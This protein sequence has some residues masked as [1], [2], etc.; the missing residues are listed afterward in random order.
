VSGDESLATA[1]V[2]SARRVHVPALDGMR[3]IGILA[4]MVIHFARVDPGGFGVHA[5]WKAAV[6]VAAFALPMF[7]VLSGFLITGILL[8]TREKPHYFR[9]FYVRRALRILPLYYGVLA[10][11]FVVHPSWGRGLGGTSS[12]L[13][14]WT[15]VANFE[16]ARRGHCT[17]A[18]LCHFWSL[19]V[20]EQYYLVWPL[21]VFALRP[22]RLLAICAILGVASVIL[23]IAFTFVW[24][25]SAA[26]YVLTPCQ[27]DPL[28]AGGALAV[29][30]RK[31]S[32]LDLRVV[33]RFAVSISVAAFFL[34]RWYKQPM[35]SRQVVVGGPLLLC[36]LV[37]GIILLAIGESGFFR[38][39]LGTR[40]LT[41]LGKYSYGLYVFHSPL[42]PFLDR[43]FPR[44]D[45]GRALGSPRAGLAVSVLMSITATLVVAIA[46]FELVEKR[47]LRLKAW[48][49]GREERGVKT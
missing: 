31:R 30:V 36:F 32:L 26:A 1:P 38:A 9:N 43:C 25:N 48:F 8:E 10:L 35:M 42:M 34:L 28:C 12:P 3:G 2:S 13:W 41:F 7:F 49:G 46:S 14:L 27:L 5:E 19:T 20:E 47:F 11:L 21:I 16:M 29:L 23:R 18:F 40:P 39:V 4:V 22:R 6:D 45:L 33:A 17:Y 44:S 37:G 15:Y 24:H